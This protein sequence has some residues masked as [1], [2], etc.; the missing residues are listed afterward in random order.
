MSQYKF[1]ILKSIT[2]LIILGEGNTAHEPCISRL[3]ETMQEELR[4]KKKKNVEIIHLS[5]MITRLMMG[6]RFASCKSGKDRTSMAATLEQVQILRNDY[7]LA[8]HEFQLALDAMR[9]YLI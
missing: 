1:K 2:Q 6:L 7:D 9:R 3:L 4:S 8:E 5:G